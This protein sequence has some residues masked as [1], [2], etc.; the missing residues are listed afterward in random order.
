MLD[1][2]VLM[3]LMSSISIAVARHATKI[4]AVALAPPAGADG[5]VPA[6]RSGAWLLMWRGRPLGGEAASRSR[7]YVPRRRSVG[8]LAAPRPTCLPYSCAA[9]GA[10][11][12]RHTRSATHQ[13]ASDAPD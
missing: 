2:A 9:G 1:R 7:S 11:H 6:G 10:R 13:G 4:V 5:V 3:T 8:G 12:W